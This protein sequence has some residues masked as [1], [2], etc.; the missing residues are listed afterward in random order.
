MIFLKYSKN[1]WLNSNFLNFDEI[2]AQM[3]ENRTNNITKGLN[4][5]LN[6]VMECYYSKISIF[7]SK[8]KEI[9]IVYY[10]KY[11]EN[12]VKKENKTDL[13]FNDLNEI[14]YYTSKI[15]S[16]YENILYF[17]ILLQIRQEKLNEINQ[18]EENY[19]RSA[20]I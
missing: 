15:F 2:S 5:N 8:L 4:H 16:K 9:I 12:Q 11:L 19:K 13:K 17:N 6:K 18:I 1:N 7:V 10:N 3:F 14:Y 20:D